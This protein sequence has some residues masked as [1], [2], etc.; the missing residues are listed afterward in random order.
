MKNLDCKFLM[1]FLGS[2]R[3]FYASDT[4]VPIK[5]K[6]FKSRKMS[7]YFSIENVY[8]ENIINKCIYTNSK[9]L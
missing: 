6:Y 7:F 9:K 4:K 3:Q 8:E 5:A 1:N 2:I